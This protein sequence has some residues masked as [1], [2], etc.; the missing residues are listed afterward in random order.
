M[1]RSGISWHILFVAFH[2]LQCDGT[3][4]VHIS[5]KEG[6]DDSSGKACEMSIE[7]F[8]EMDSCIHRRVCGWLCL[9]E[10]H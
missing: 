8:I 10:Y 1:W 2:P 4:G 9:S 3:T 6:H 5:L 7:S